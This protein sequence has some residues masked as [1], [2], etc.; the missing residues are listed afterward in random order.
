MKKL[1]LMFVAVTSRQLPLQILQLILLR[2]ILP[3]LTAL[4]PIAPLLIALL[5]PPL[6]IQLLRQSNLRKRT[7][8]LRIAARLCVEFGGFFVYYSLAPTV[9]AVIPLAGSPLSFSAIK[10]TSVMH[11]L[12]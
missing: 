11:S 6:L 5:L 3:L 9:V 8:N 4:L 12:L 2:L 1:V 10:I 7:E